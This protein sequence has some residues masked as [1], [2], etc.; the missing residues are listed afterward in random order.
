MSF[1]NVWIAVGM[2]SDR[3]SCNQQFKGLARND[4]WNEVRVR[5]NEEEER[6]GGESRNGSELGP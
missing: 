3:S 4:I 1:F 6:G 5:E 2:M